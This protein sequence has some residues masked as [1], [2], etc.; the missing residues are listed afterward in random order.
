MRNNSDE[1]EQRR[2]YILTLT[3]TAAGLFAALADFLEVVL[4]LVEAVF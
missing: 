1:S 2:S 3:G 4:R